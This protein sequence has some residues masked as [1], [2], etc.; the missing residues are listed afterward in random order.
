MAHIA[1]HPPS[2]SPILRPDRIVVVGKRDPYL[3]LATKTQH[4]NKT[5]IF[6]DE[7]VAWK[8]SWKA[9]TNIG[10]FAKRL[11]QQDFCV[12]GIGLRVFFTASAPR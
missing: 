8:R 6:I 1:P 9:K 3:S 12:M 2:H 5:M 10:Q 11:P 7:H 4:S